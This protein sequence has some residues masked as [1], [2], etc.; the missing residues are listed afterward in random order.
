LKQGEALS[1]L[2][3]NFTLEYNIR[4]VQENQEVLKLNGTHHLLA[5]DDDDNIVGESIE[6]IKKNI[7]TLLGASKEVGLEVNPEKI[8]IS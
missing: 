8:N 3:F 1:S 2:L 6:N 4:R 7:K 5:Y